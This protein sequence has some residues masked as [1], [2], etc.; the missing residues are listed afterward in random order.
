M[1]LRTLHSNMAIFTAPSIL[2]FALTGAFQLFDLHES[3]GSYRA[4]VLIE[5]LGRLHKDQVFAREDRH[6]NADP[7]KPVGGTPGIA[8]TAAPAAAAVDAGDPVS[9]S[10]LKWFFLLVTLV[11]AST[12]GLGLWL[13]LRRSPRRSLSWFLL[14]SGL[15]LP[16]VIVVL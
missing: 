11:L 5:R 9:A 14:L 7:D 6:P 10:V 16:V 15:V 4:P 2:F 3:H 8:G 1:R 12:T 13:G